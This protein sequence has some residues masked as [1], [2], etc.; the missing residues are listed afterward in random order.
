MRVM[1]ALRV[2]P[3]MQ[4]RV[5]GAS[6]AVWVKDRYHLTYGDEKERGLWDSESAA[7]AHKLENYEELVMV[8]VED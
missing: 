3:K 5:C 6:R 7:L 1:W 2:K 8:E 4:R